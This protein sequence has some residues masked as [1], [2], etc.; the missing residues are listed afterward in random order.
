MACYKCIGH[1]LLSPLCLEAS[2][3]RK[4]KVKQFLK[5]AIKKIT[6]ESNTN[7]T[8]FLKRLREALHKFT[9]LDLDSYK[10]QVILKD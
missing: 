9:N 2:V 5:S 7:P 6:Q 3:F 10:G 4:C 1:Y 8:A